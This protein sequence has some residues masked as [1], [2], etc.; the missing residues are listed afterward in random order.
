MQRCT[1]YR[2]LTLV[3]ANKGGGGDFW[4]D[5]DYDVR[6][7]D[8]EGPVV[9]RVRP[10]D[11]RR[12]CR[13]AATMRAGSGDG[14]FQGAIVGTMTEPQGDRLVSPQIKKLRSLPVDQRITLAKAKMDRV[15][16]H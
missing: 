11:V 8:A 3:R 2:L 6:L 15:L 16:D 13:T 1:G 10:A 7:G 12:R 5:D 9:G 4:S 14:R